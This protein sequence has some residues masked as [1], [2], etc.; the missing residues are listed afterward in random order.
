MNVKVKPN[1][2]DNLKIENFGVGEDI[3][4]SILETTKRMISWGLAMIAM[5]AML[6]QLLDGQLGEVDNSYIDMA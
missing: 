6:I 2:K 3:R 4:V 1:T 5:T